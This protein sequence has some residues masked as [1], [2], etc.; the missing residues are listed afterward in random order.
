MSIAN[1]I[2]YVLVIVGA[3]NWGLF[4]LFNLN[5]VDKVF[6][7]ARAAGSVIVYTVIAI[8]ALW[9]ILS[10]FITGGVLWLKNRRAER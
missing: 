10:P 2:A 4:G 8:A 5:L 9:L 3:I 7:G 1:I 6:A